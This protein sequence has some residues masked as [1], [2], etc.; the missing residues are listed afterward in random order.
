MEID[1]SLRL[2][3][4]QARKE[5]LPDFKDFKNAPAY[6]YLVRKKYGAFKVNINICYLIL[7]E[8]TPSFSYHCQ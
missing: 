4:L 2:K 5:N 8:Y 7:E 3:L 6:E 1:N